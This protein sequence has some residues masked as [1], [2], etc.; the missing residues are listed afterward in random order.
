[1][2]DLTSKED[3]QRANVEQ[4]RYYNRLNQMNNKQQQIFQKYLVDH[5]VP[6]KDKEKQLEEIERKKRDETRVRLDALDKGSRLNQKAIKKEYQK[7]LN[8]QMRQREKEHDLKNQAKL[9]TLNQMK[10]FAMMEVEKDKQD[11]MNRKYMQT[12]YRN[13]LQS[14]EYLKAKQKLNTEIKLHN[15]T[16]HAPTA[17]DLYTF[18]GN[19][20]SNGEF[21][22]IEKGYISPNPIVNP[23]SDPMYNPYFRRDISEGIHS[24]KR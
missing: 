19:Y 13:A 11:K 17:D 18:G 20:V 4:D 16:D 6:T 14:Q 21:K 5:L 9:E 2:K 24:I 7:Y 8:N 12:T 22:S 1:M 3:V 23:I 15:A 10:N